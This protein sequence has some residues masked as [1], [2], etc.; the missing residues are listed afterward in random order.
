M[1]GTQW[2][3]NSSDTLLN[4]FFSQD[5]LKQLAVDAGI[6]LECPLLVLDDTFHVVAYYYPPGFVDNIFQEAVRCGQITYEAGAIISRSSALCS[7]MSDYIKLE[8]SSFRRRF[9]PLS[10]AGVSLGYLVCVDT[11]GHLQQIPSQTW[12]T[13]EMILAKQLFVS[14]SRKDKSFE[15]AADILINLLDG[16]FSSEAYFQLQIANTYL[17][18]FHPSA[19]ALIDLSAYH[20]MYQ[21]KRHLKEEI[22][23]RFPSS[24][25]FVY[26]GEVFLFLG[27]TKDMKLFFSLSEE[28]HLKIIISDPVNT[29][30]S[31]PELYRTAREALELMRDDRFQG[32]GVCMVSQLRTALLLH[33][34]KD[35][36]DLISPEVRKLAFY[37]R[38]KDAQ[39]CETL[40]W[41]LA[42]GRS[43]K[44]TC[45]SLYTHRNTVLYRIR[46]MQE[47]FSIPLNE[48]S[49]YAGLLL[50]VSMSLFETRG[51]GFFVEKYEYTD[52]PEQKGELGD[53]ETSLQS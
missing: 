45:D 26:Q 2:E 18:E 36:S 38:K 1:D 25:S 31:L 44:K 21:G 4:D 22:N 35:R 23:K 30:F 16:G 28:F 49:A 43:L 6:M 41:Y 8:E 32:N 50:G 17:A 10:S 53:C 19:F 48:G 13:V 42:Y 3:C 11:D 51:A 29:M 34:I 27:G 20:S 52:E 7:G 9:V 5:D 24:H 46:K 15:T 37:D 40:Y 47:D 33:S 39:Y 14:A 12:H